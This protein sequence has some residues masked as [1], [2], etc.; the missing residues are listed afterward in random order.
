MTE[1]IQI[2][3]L[4]S[5]MFGFAAAVKTVPEVSDVCPWWLSLT[6]TVF[7]FVVF[8]ALWPLLLGMFVWERFAG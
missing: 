4:L 7:V 1:A 6:V 3:L 8:F 2:Y 5:A